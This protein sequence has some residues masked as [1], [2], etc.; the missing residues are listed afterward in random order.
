MPPGPLPRRRGAMSGASPPSIRLR[1]LRYLS[2]L[3][4]TARP[5]RREGGRLEEL[6][7][8]PHPPP[9]LLPSC[10]AVTLLAGAGL[11]GRSPRYQAG[12]G[13]LG[14]ARGA[15]PA[16]PAIR[17]HRCG[18]SSF[19]VSQWKLL[20]LKRSRPVTEGCRRL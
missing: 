7:S 19:H 11:R 12:E 17:Q 20:P 9:L 10:K 14:A 1:P 16:L 6:F 8:L 5:L 3:V 2:D 13:H 15:V 18:A 4:T